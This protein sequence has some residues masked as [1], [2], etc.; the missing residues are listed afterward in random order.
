M[1]FM[2]DHLW[3]GKPS[4]F[5]K[6]MQLSAEIIYTREQTGW[7]VESLGFAGTL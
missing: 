7:K 4:P 1:K 6:Q 5:V 2:A 3:V